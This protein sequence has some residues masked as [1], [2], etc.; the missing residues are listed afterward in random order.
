MLCAADIGARI[1][2]SLLDG[3]VK[4]HDAEDNHGTSA[5]DVGCVILLAYLVT[6]DL[7]C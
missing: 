1:C 4:L 3:M 6:L 7:S 5:F 2:V